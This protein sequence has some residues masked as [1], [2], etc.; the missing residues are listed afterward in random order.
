[1]SAA[2]RRILVGRGC[3]CVCE[4]VCSY[5]Q[6]YPTHVLLVSV[7]PCLTGSYFIYCL[8]HTVD[9]DIAVICHASFDCRMPACRLKITHWR[10]VIPPYFCWVWKKQRRHRE[11]IKKYHCD[12]IVQS[13]C[14]KGFSLHF[15]PTDLNWRGHWSPFSHSQSLSCMTEHGP[16]VGHTHSCENMKSVYLEKLS[17]RCS[18]AYFNGEPAIV[19]GHKKC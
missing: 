2:E 18:L 5:R 17:I 3:V 11:V 9:A 16:C 1:M 12:G 13:L 14:T 10:S 15:S 7:L 6:A 4:F 8:L 19:R